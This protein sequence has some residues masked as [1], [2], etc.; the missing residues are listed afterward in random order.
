MKKLIPGIIIFAIVYFV[1]I[2]NAKSDTQLALQLI[3]PTTSEALQ[4]TGKPFYLLGNINQ[5][6]VK[7]KV[8]GIDATIDSDG[9]FLVYAPIILFNENNVEKG[10]FIFDIESKTENIKVEKVFNINPRIKTTDFNNS[11]I[12]NEW[13]N[14]PFGENL[15]QVG[16][17]ID[18]EIKA[19]P[20]AKLFYKL[21]G[22]NT[23]FPLYEDSIVTDYLRPDAI[24][25]DGFKGEKYVVNGIYKGSFKVYSALQNSIITV[26]GT[27]QNGKK[28]EQNL[29]ARISTI[30]QNLPQIIKT[31]YNENKTVAR[32]GAGLG[33]ALFLDEDV[34]LLVTGKSDGFFRCQIADDENIYLNE[35]QV[36][37]VVEGSNIPRNVIDIIRS[38]EYEDSLLVQI[39]F[40]ERVP[41]KIEQLDSPN[42]ILLTLYNSTSNIDFIRYQR[43]TEFLK[44][45]RWNQIK[46]NVITI[47][48]LLNQKTHWG[49]KTYYN[50]NVLNLRVNKPAMRN[51]TFL[52]WGN[53][54]ENRKIVI[55]PGHTPESGA[56]GPAGNTEK[57]IN[58][59]ISRKVKN[60][61]LTKG[62]IVFLTH[63]GEGLQLTKRKAR[64]NTFY[65][66]ISISIHNN[67]VPQNVNPLIHNGASVYYYYQQ[68]LPLAKNIHSE[69]LKNLGLRD[70]GLYWDNLYMCRIPETIA[71]LVEPAFII[72][73]YQEKLLMSDDFQNSIAISIVNALEKFYEEYSE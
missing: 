55:D 56:V 19:A 11:S 31:R 64:V 8:N 46:K 26:S 51:S 20:G 47:E 65:G 50:N 66:E 12:D 24:F 54:L 22:V 73:P 2:Y 62:A 42:R 33:Y 3:F 41:F 29:D 70:F 49:Y 68:A 48:I 23:T 17:F 53:Q 45:I 21:S 69:F 44:E 7:L 10:K 13:K 40:D 61:L 28:F 4:L 36:D 27:L 67:A 57:E 32:Y 60:L 71:L 30:S 25:G 43:T 1:S 58:L 16:E 39:G 18:V 6:D 5:K 52:F 15:V 34:R 63:D 35:N 38:E 14:K 72:H 9:A 59:A 37:L